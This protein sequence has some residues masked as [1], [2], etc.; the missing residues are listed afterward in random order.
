[1]GTAKTG[2]LSE[3]LKGDGDK[4]LISSPSDWFTLP[5]PTGETGATIASSPGH[6][7]DV[8]PATGNSQ[9][10][11]AGR[12]WVRGDYATSRY[13]HVMPPNGKSCSHNFSGTLTAT[14]INEQGGAHT[15]SSHH[16]GGVN[17]AC[18]DGS[19]RFIAD[20]VDPSVWFAAGSKNGDETVSGSF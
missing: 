13:N 10:P 15:A 20:S 11:C 17:L 6:C 7:P 9:F 3:M 18:V 14:Q 5:G 16:P 19:L 1:D 2:L 8:A 12:N 4:N